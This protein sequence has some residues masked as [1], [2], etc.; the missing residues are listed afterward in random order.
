LVNHFTNI[1]YCSGISNKI[2][3]NRMGS[4]KIKGDFWGGPSPTLFGIHKKE[5]G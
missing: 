1:Y 2:V 4:I 3:E 5:K